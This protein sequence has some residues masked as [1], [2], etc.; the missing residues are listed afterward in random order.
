VPVQ[1]ADP[2]KWTQGWRT[3]PL[4]ALVML[5]ALSSAALAAP[6]SIGQLETQIAG[7]DRDAL[8]ELGL[9]YEH[10]EGV[11]RD[12]PHAVALYC[13][14]AAGGQAAA[15]YQLGLMRLN[16]RGVERDAGQAVF[17]LQ[18]AAAA[19]HPHA[20]RLLERLAAAA[21]PDAVLCPAPPKP[22]AKPPLPPREI[23]QAVKRLAPRY[24]LDP[25]LVTAVIAVESGFQT[26]ALSP[27]NAQGLMQLIPETATRFGVTNA[28]DPTQNL[29]GGMG[30]LR[31]LLR[32]F[33]GDVT[34][35]LAGYNAGENAVLAHGGV[36]P[37]RET[38]DYVA[39]IRRYYPSRQHPVPALP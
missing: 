16:G 31:W 30:Y 7:G 28:F 11:A 36:P 4:L 6:T 2:T 19:G 9:R 22:E 20:P 8:V 5:A 25:A 34:L 39:K 18:Q 3:L 35:A 12:Y 1:P 24:G 14:A 21:Q 10:A 32:R 15:I 38:Q 13:E 23:A 33:D 37:Y 27:K 26:A 17:W 29:E